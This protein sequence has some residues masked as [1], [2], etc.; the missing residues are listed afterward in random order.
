MLYPVILAG[1][2][3]K[4]LWPLSSQAD[5]KQFQALLGKQTLLQTT[6]QRLAIGFDKKNIFLVTADNA[7][8]AV[9]KQI[10]INKQNILLEPMIKGTAMA[11]GLAALKIS[12]ID[13]EATMV[14]INSDAYVKDEN[15]YIKV[16]EQAAQIVDQQV[17]KM[18]LIGIKP[19][20]PETGYGYI[21]MGQEA[22]KGVYQVKSFKE[23]PDVDT[24]KK[25]LEQ[26]NYFWNPTIS[27]F[28]AKQLLE[29]YQKFLPN[30]YQALMAI[31]KNE[32]SLSE[33]Y[34]KVD[35]ICI[36][37]G[38]FEKLSDMLV[39]PA[40]FG[41]WADIGHWRSVRDVLADKPGDNVVK[42]KDKVVSVDSKNNLLYSFSDKLIATVGVEDMILVETEDTIFL[43]PADRAQEVKE[44]LKKIKGSDLEKYL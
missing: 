31:E 26:G 43:C 41:E 14:N 36:N 12:A 18:V 8:E 44:V 16:I 15:A 4:R 39:I 29:W 40:D 34:S 32:A 2:V 10:D 24:A 19:A 30:T 37:I 13:P 1:G 38:L 35:N 17:N 25:F 23:K 27:I 33:E 7:L 3:G 20:Y 28:K 21:E 5:P 42:N 11:I 22:D 6:Y 9:K